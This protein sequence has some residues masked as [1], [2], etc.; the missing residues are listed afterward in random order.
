MWHMQAS[1]D[2]PKVDARLLAGEVIIWQD[3]A[4]ALFLS[5]SMSCPWSVLCSLKLEFYLWVLSDSLVS[6]CQKSLD[7][8]WQRKFSSM[9][10]EFG[11]TSC[12]I[13]SC[14]SMKN[15][16]F[17]CL[18]PCHIFWVIASPR[19]SSGNPL[20]PQQ[21]SNLQPGW[22]AMLTTRQSLLVGMHPVYCS[23][24]SPF[25]QW[26]RQL[27]V[28]AQFQLANKDPKYLAAAHFPFSA[29]PHQGDGEEN[30]E[31]KQNRVHG[32]R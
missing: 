3:K 30:Q 20:F 29:H 12:W 15:I 8:I 5:T 27:S 2:L 13:G 28:M 4:S 21:H 32:L 6:T 9:Y 19:A 16:H 23:R 24:R 7:C 1:S 10:A 25:L 17:S 14:S 11:I 31:R 26:Y 22:E 18:Q